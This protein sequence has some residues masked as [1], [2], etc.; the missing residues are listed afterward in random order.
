MGRKPVPPA[1]DG[2]LPDLETYPAKDLPLLPG[3]GKLDLEACLALFDIR[4]PAVLWK[5][6]FKPCSAGG[7]IKM[8]LRACGFDPHSAN[9]GWR[10]PD[11]HGEK[12]PSAWPGSTSPAQPAGEETRPAAN[13]RGP[14]DTTDIPTALQK[15]GIADPKSLWQHPVEPG[16]PRHALKKE[17]ARALARRESIP[18]ITREDI[19]LSS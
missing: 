15:L 14:E 17:I 2:I 3:A 11:P 7:R 1:C 16:S 4:D 9:A 13:Q 6:R 19:G 5:R 12:S 18:G 10:R 8:C